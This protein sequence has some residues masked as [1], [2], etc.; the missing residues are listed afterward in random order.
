MVLFR[1]NLRVPDI[2]SLTSRGRFMRQIRAEKRES[3]PIR[4]PHI[5]PHV[6][7]MNFERTVQIAKDQVIMN[8]MENCRNPLDAVVEE[9]R[10]RCVALCSDIPLYRVRH[11]VADYFLFPFLWNVVLTGGLILLPN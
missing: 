8:T 1:H 4:Q 2:S 9:V 11:R 5:A 6:C 3:S 10:M 7:D